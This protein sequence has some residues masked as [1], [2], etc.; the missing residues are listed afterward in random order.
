[1]CEQELDAIATPG[2]VRVMPDIE[3]LHVRPN[4]IDVAV[5]MVPH[6][7]YHQQGYTVCSRSSTLQT[8]PEPRSFSV[9]L[10]EDESENIRME[11][12]IQ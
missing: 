11:S 3:L 1:M 6:H 7:A 9:F 4:R 2:K 12:V 8:Y 5:S 10:Q